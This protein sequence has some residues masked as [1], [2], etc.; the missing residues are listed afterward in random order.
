MLPPSAV[1]LMVPVAV[2]EPADEMLRTP[3]TVGVAVES[4]WTR[5]RLSTAC[6]A[7]FTVTV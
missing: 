4:P 7:A 3:G 6:M 2:I 1:T 5:I